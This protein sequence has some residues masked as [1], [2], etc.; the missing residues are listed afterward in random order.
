M[1]RLFGQGD[2]R[3]PLEFV[4]HALAARLEEPTQIQQISNL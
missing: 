4:Q 3:F 2:E 1:G